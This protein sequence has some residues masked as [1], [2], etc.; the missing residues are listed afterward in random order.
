MTDIEHEIA[1]F[2]HEE[3]GRAALPEGMDQRVFRRAKI[4]RLAT[5]TIAGVA[6][7]ATV[8]AGAVMAGAFRSPSSLDPVAPGESP[9]PSATPRE[10]GDG[11]HTGGP[12][13]VGR[14]TV[15]GKSWTL[16]AYESDAGLCVDFELGDGAVGG[17][18]IDVPES[19]DLS[20]SVGYLDGL[21]RTIIH[22]VVSK[23]VVALMGTL[24]GGEELDV[25]IIE[26]PDAF[27]VNFFVAFVPLTAEGV[28]KAQGD[29]GV[30]L[31]RARITP[32]SGGPSSDCSV[33]PSELPS[34]A[35]PGSSRSEEG[36]DGELLIWGDGA[37]Q[38]ALL[39]EIPTWLEREEFLAL[40]AD[41]LQRVAV[42]G[43]DGVLIPVG[44]PPASQIILSWEEGRCGYV[45]W[46]GPGLELEAAADYA[47]RF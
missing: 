46:L 39:A 47:S 10:N 5:A 13:V 6:V 19:H 15:S 4:R 20:L 7:F 37:D 11:E 31:E 21:S 14:G 43:N 40:P 9:R 22:G 18:G 33:E 30:V 27:D 16:T 28:L 3:A 32:A 25:Q 35:S 38:V 45:V 23:R 26:G 44:E 41:H 36:S 29:E 42:R 8:M 12:E 1:A 2:L 17:C 24:D 34:G